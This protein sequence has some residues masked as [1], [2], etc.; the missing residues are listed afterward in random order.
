MGFFFWNF[1][2]VSEFDEIRNVLL[3]ENISN[4]TNS[5]NWYKVWVMDGVKTLSHVAVEVLV[6]QCREPQDGADFRV[7]DLCVP[8]SSWAD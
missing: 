1:V 8:P 2:Y 4:L 5:E 3:P 6:H 7:R